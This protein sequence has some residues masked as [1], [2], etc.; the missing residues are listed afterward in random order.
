MSA[1][2]KY[3]RQPHLIAALILI[4]AAMGI[5]SFTRLPYNLFP[6]THY[7][8]VAVILVWPGASAQD[9]QAEVA[10]EVDR[11]LAGL[12]RCRSVRAV[13]R[14]GVA[15][16]TAEFEYGKGIESAL[17][18]VRSALDR[19]TASLPRQLQPPRIFPVTDATA[20]V[21]TMAVRAPP[22]SDMPL[23]R[24]RQI[25]ANGLREAL[26]RIKGVS[27]VEIFGGHAPQVRIEL[28]PD[29][30]ASFGI[31]LEGILAAVSVQNR[32][33]P[34]GVLKN[35]PGQFQLTL[36][37]RSV[38]PERLEEIVLSRGPDGP[39]RLGDVAGIVV[40]ERDR[41]S[42]FHGSGRPAIGVNILRSESGH[43][44][45]TLGSLEERLPEL[46]REFSNLDMEIVDTTGELI[47]TSIANMI[48]ALRDAVLLTIGVVFL[49][50]A[51][52]RATLLTAVSIPCTFLLTFAG[53]GLLGLELNIV[54]MTGI[55]LAIGL[56]VDDSIVVIESID[57][58][59]RTQGKTRWRAVVDGTREIYLA[60]FSGTLTTVAVLLPIM[61]LGGY[62]QK[63]L[64][65]LCMVLTLALLSSYAVS[66][67]V[68]PLLAPRLKGSTRLEELLG[69]GLQ[70][71]SGRIMN[72]LQ[73]MFTA[74]YRFAASRRLLFIVLGAGLLVVSMRQVPL[75]GRDLMPPMDTGILMVDFRAG[76]GASLER[77]E[78]VASAME[79][80]IREM[81]GLEKM[82]AL[83]GSESGVIS[84]GAERT[85]QEG[86]ITAHFVDRFHR[87]RSI[88][89]IQRELRE[90]F[91]DIP[92]LHSFRVYGYGATPL[93]SISAPVD[94]RVSGPDPQVL[95]RIADRV[96]ERLRSVRGLTGI[97]RSW[98]MDK[99]EIVLDAD[100]DRLARH[101]LT[102][103][104]LSRTLNAATQGLDASLLRVPEQ[105]GYGISL[106]FR[107]ERSEGLQDLRELPVAT[108]EGHVPLGELGDFRRVR[109]Q[110][111]MVR[112]DMQQAVDVYGYRDTASISFIQGQVRERLR[113]LQLPGGYRLSQEGEIK[114]MRE[115]FSRLGGALLVAL[116]LVYF[117]MVPTFRSFLH[118][119]T[120]MGAI[121][122]AFIG[123]SW[124]LL[125]AGRHFCMPAFMGMIL[126]SGLVV[127]NSILLLDYT[128]R[129]REGGAGREEA[130]EAAIRTRTRPIVMTA[131]STIAGMLPIALE[132]AIGL[133]RL[134]PLAVA[135]IGGL[136]AS[137]FLTLIYVP[138]IYSLADDARARLG[139]KSGPAGR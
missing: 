37:G 52:P 113:D 10:R 118:P 100:R 102:P 132:L 41:F 32:N 133:E 69:R 114:N 24:V 79:A 88:W 136:I 80:R 35:G 67:T 40:S 99:P 57:R 138:V 122:L 93:S 126:L 119:V 30:M 85:P 104:D 62:T 83:G 65:P 3:L 111:S 44:T 11:E 92:G 15:A 123:V 23:F 7:P 45:E 86:H 5:L 105:T 124:S 103:R 47:R 137:T 76:S 38:D 60:D 14:T 28:D 51:R 84:F 39:V 106:R 112:Q 78:E 134:S 72:A 59:L 101:G 16:V 71:V 98:Y 2:E 61:F 91:R 31:G 50:L 127:N 17:G 75:I 125:L 121:P 56:L 43:V 89:D 81:N 117:S 135:A 1:V 130:L 42:F 97:T 64:R 36:Q 27:D 8:T 6:D 25:C 22:D 12:N 110:S 68:I 49:L 29:R 82:S 87:K 115:S 46:R 63:I 48:S 90:E 55:I 13:S 139:E 131:A 34:G 109:T 96:A 128:R 129:A 77:T 66:I 53:M 4:G 58:H 33:I 94:V 120:I 26:L 116:V 20:P 9:V 107:P 18:D 54:T 74:L 108:S 70:R 19:I 73:S 95:D 21:A